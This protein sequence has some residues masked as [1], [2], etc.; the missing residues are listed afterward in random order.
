MVFWHKAQGWMLDTGWLV[1]LLLVFGYF[2]Q[3]RQ[4]LVNAQGWLITKGHITS[5]K[6]TQAGHS[7][8]PEIEYK[9]EVYNRVLYGHY[10]FLDT[11][12]NTPNSAYARQIAYKVAL[13]FKEN[14]EI[15]VYYNPNKPEQSAL[16]LSIPKKLNL[17][18]AINAA[19]ILVQVLVII[20]RHW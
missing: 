11:T 10:L 1:I 20:W 14:S 2:W 18:L 12:H 3:R 8:W 9:Y 7:V 13:A 5:C 6:W 16:D 4:V 19:F 17:I 15:D